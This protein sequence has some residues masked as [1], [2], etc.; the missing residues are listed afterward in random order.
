[1]T[2]DFH[3]MLRNDIERQMIEGSLAVKNL[4]EAWN[5]KVKEYLGVDVTDDSH[6]VLQ[7]VHWSGG[8]VGFRN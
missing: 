8:Q 2:Y 1:M 4:P 5:T 6:G 7:E 3:I